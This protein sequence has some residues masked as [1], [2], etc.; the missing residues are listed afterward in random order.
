MKTLQTLFGRELYDYLQILAK[1]QSRIGFDSLKKSYTTK[2]IA[3]EIYSNEY[4]SLDHLLL[5][6]L[7][8]FMKSLPLR[9][10]DPIAI[11]SLIKKSLSRFISREK[12]SKEISIGLTLDDVKKEPG[13]IY[14]KSK[15]YQ[16]VSSMD[17]IDA[18]IDRGCYPIDFYVYRPKTEKKVKPE[19]LRKWLARREHSITF[20]DFASLCDDKING[21]LI[22]I[23]ERTG[24]LPCIVLSTAHDG[25]NSFKLRMSLVD[26]Q[27]GQENLIM[28]YASE[29][30]FGVRLVHHKAIINSEVLEE[31]LSTMT[32]G[33]QELVEQITEMQSFKFRK[34][35]LQNVQE[36]VLKM[37]F[38]RAY[39]KNPQSF[40]V[41]IN[42]WFALDAPV[43]DIGLFSD[44]SSIIISDDTL[45]VWERMMLIQSCIY[46]GFEYQRK[47]DKDIRTLTK[48]PDYK[49]YKHRTAIL[50]KLFDVCSYI[51]KS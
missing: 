14:D 48:K 5:S 2:S 42:H 25:N 26:M 37:L 40:I 30:I 35:E 32:E 9:G 46:T 21:T 36:K 16:F 19:N 38:G 28:A 10:K 23:Y 11:Q 34:W 22:E 31:T 47:Y 6:S 12:L 4:S 50:G 27:T 8:Q 20:L 17:V 18:L 49:N 24:L 45:S 15:V 44:V 7:D 51:L 39:E 33:Y 41:N 1:I 43:K 29:S 13:L 3:T